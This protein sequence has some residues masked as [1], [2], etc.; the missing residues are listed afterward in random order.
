MNTKV[1]GT[2]IKIKVDT[3][4]RQCKNYLK[5]T[6]DH[7]KVHGTYFFKLYYIQDVFLYRNGESIVFSF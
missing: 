7:R 5:D 1:G 2:Y 6:E 3:Q 4:K